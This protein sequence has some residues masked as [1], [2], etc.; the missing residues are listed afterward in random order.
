M[1]TKEKKFNEKLEE[2]KKMIS[3]NRPKSEI[4]RM[5]G[6]KYETMN[7]Y[8]KK[9][10][11]DYKGNPHRTG[12]VHEESRIPLSKI[13]NNEVV[14]STASL[15]KR[16]VEECLKEYK[17][18]NPD[19]GISEWNGKE[20]P[21]ELH[22]IDGNHYNNNLDNLQLLCPNCHAQTEF[23]RGR[24]KKKNNVVKKATNK[25]KEKKYCESCGEEIIGENSY[26][27]KYCSPECYHKHFLK[28]DVSKEQLLNDFKELKTY[29]SVGKKYGVSDKA[30]K[31]RVLKFGILDDIKK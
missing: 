4:S 22:H 8:F 12:F 18:E 15:K 3:E 21:L 19:C 14:Y 17:C 31:K 29:V 9:Y 10:G 26:R 23:F 1:N 25:N 13:L 6:M 16:L 28:F 24:K 11:I 27:K 2:I 20:L 5:L 30:I 7:G